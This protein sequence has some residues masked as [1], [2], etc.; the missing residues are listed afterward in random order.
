MLKT[1][2]MMWGYGALVALTFIILEP[3]LLCSHC[4][5]YTK[6]GKILTC[7]GL[8]GMPKWW[9]YHPEPIKPWE[10][11]I[12]LILG[13]VIDLVPFL[14]MIGGVILFLLHISEYLIYGIGLTI[15]SILF[16]GLAYYFSKVLLGDRCKRCPNFSCAMNK[17]PK[18]LVMQFLE[19]NTVMQKA[20]EQS[21]YF[22]ESNKKID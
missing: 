7:G 15:F 5:F 19:K 9:K 12:M 22:R 4:P 2:W 21:G 20:W 8:Y 3:R 10:K 11:I 14:G 16:L 1:W 18:E 6:P 17:V 13:S